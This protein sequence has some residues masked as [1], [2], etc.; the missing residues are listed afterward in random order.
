MANEI[1]AEMLALKVT[2][3]ETLPGFIGFANYWLM[4]HYALASLQAERAKDALQ[5]QPTEARKFDPGTPILDESGKLQGFKA[6]PSGIEY[7]D[8]TVTSDAKDAPERVR[9]WVSGGTISFTEDVLSTWEAYGQPITPG[10]F[11]PDTKGSTE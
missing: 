11:T 2:E 6:H 3:L 8:N 10:W 9:C 1:T 5:V 7:L 4:A